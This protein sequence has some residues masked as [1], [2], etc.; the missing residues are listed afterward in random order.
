MRQTEGIMQRLYESA[1]FYRPERMSESQARHT[2][3]LTGKFVCP[4]YD[5]ERI[6]L[7]AEQRHIQQRVYSMLLA[8]SR[9]RRDTVFGCVMEDKLS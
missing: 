1:L 4:E 9:L 7:D 5:D 2:L 3:N 8:E 6:P